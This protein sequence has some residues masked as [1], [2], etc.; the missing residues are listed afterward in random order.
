MNLRHKV[1]NFQ[2]KM[3]DSLLNICT[4][5]V[6]KNLYLNAEMINYKEW[7]LSSSIS[8]WIFLN[9]VKYTDFLNMEELEFFCFPFVKLTTLLITP[10]FYNFPDFFSKISI[11]N[12]KEIDVTLI[13]DSYG[14]KYLDCLQRLSEQ[15]LSVQ[16]LKLYFTFSF[17]CDVL[18]RS[19]TVELLEKSLRL[20]SNY[21]DCSTTELRIEAKNYSNATSSN[22]FL[23]FANILKKCENL[24]I[25]ELNNRR[26]RGSEDTDLLSIVNLPLSSSLNE[27]KIHISIKTFEIMENFLTQFKHLKIFGLHLI[28]DEF[29][30]INYDVVKKIFND[31]LPSK[32]TLETLEIELPNNYFEMP[33]F[34]SDFKQLRTFHFN[35]KENVIFEFLLHYDEVIGWVNK[36]K[37]LI[38]FTESSQSRKIIHKLISLLQNRQSIFD[39]IV[40]FYVLEERELDDNLDEKLLKLSK[41]SKQPIRF[42]LFSENHEADYYNPYV[43]QLLKNCKFID[44]YLNFVLEDNDNE[45]KLLGFESYLSTVDTDK[46]IREEE[47]RIDFESFFKNC[48]R[49]HAISFQHEVLNEIFNDI[50]RAILNS[51]ETLQYIEF[52]GCLNEKNSENFLIL[53]QN[54]KRLSYI[55]INGSNSFA[56]KNFINKK[57]LREFENL[58]SSLTHLRFPCSMKY[59]DDVYRLARK[60]QDI[61]CFEMKIVSGELSLRNWNRFASIFYC[62]WHVRISNTFNAYRFKFN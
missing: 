49:L 14:L 39:Q 25:L 11:E 45:L 17:Q 3:A 58:G 57:I 37:S 24:Q 60:L 2:V 15:K 26:R 22:V 32:D 4:E 51:S 23:E 59:L 10:K 48:R 27:L 53:L 8:D 33:D 50:C 56:G 38:S 46:V 52:T 29:I 31:L 18:D 44:F 62:H 55:F 61:Q 47:E 12:V 6:C 1:V 40:I 42:Y 30:D 43:F 9:Y 16:K 21:L 41:Y 5:S 28:E 35:V 7:T 54:C 13:E 34:F 36:K 20:I 19:E